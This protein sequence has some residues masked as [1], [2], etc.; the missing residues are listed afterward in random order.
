MCPHGFYSYAL[1]SFSPERYLAV[2]QDPSRALIFQS[3]TD[4]ESWRVG[5]VAVAR[6]YDDGA[7]MGAAR[8]RLMFDRK[9]GA[10]SS[11]TRF[12]DGVPLRDRLS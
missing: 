6:G 12:Q 1:E 10:S 2:G 8:G 5:D 7:M 9:G 3:V 4:Y 11:E